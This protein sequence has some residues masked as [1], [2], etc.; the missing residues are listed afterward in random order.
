[1][2]L[3]ISF[4]KPKIKI[5][6]KRFYQKTFLF[7]FSLLLSNALLAVPITWTGG[8]ANNLWSN[9]ANWSTGT[10]PN[11][12]DDVTIPAGSGTI[13]F[14]YVNRRVQSLVI[15]TGSTVNILSGAKLRLIGSVLQPLFNY[16]TLLVNGKLILVNSINIGLVN[17]G[18]LDNRGIIW[19][20]NMTGTGLFNQGTV[21][22][23][24]NGEIRFLVVGGTDV[25]TSS[26]PFI[27]EGTIQFL[28]G[29][30]GEGMSVG[31][32]FEN[33]STG[34]I[35]YGDGHPGRLSISGTTG[36][37]DGDI[38]FVNSTRIGYPIYVSLNSS[39]HNGASGVIKIDGFTSPTGMIVLLNSLFE[40]EGHLGVYNDS[41]A[42]GMQ[43]N[44]TFVNEVGASI[45]M[46]DLQT[47][48]IFTNTA[49]LEN[50]GSIT[51]SAVATGLNTTGNI[52]NFSGASMHFEDGDNGIIN[53]SPGVFTNTDGEI[54]LG[55]IS[56]SDI[57]NF[58]LFYNLECGLIEGD[59]PI[60]NDATFE[61][62]GW[63]SY[64]TAG[65]NHTGASLI[66]NT[67]IV[68][69]PYDRFGTI[70]DNQ[71]TRVT[72]LTN[73]QVNVPYPDAFDVANIT[74]SD[75][76]DFYLNPALNDFAGTYDYGTN[77]YTPNKSAVGATALYTKAHQN[78][79]RVLEIRIDGSILPIVNNRPE[80]G[81][82]KRESA[83]SQNISTNSLRNFPNPTQGVFQTQL[84]RLTAG[85]Y[86]LQLLNAQGQ[87]IAK[88]QGDATL[89][90]TP[91][92]DLSE[93]PAGM[94]WTRLFVDEKLIAQ[95]KIMQIK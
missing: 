27:N 33:R 76:A 41:G 62:D 4:L 55:N 95:E 25:L 60:L 65:S 24:T 81:W 82:M 80:E 9:T 93:Y 30:T 74:G 71:E 17:Y 26:H 12:A 3:T 87:V 67:G 20:N 16:G 69:D 39:F 75:F 10:I 72:A 56:N 84:P 36:F 91:T 8:G 6:K 85:S 40:N 79:T 86:D 7:I 1:M 37:N 54:T 45:E 51:M 52:S 14:N 59:G 42:I 68:I 58:S 50:H 89:G 23:R 61:N 88:Q 83:A 49:D 32:G 94:Y 5:M 38:S 63:L 31:D 18:F 66:V 21:H 35:E 78:C 90:D 70:L 48:V 34:A 44:G 46:G 2:P 92:F 11:A 19:M 43:L 13:R 57:Q 15:N 53:Y 47:G 64:L 73:P 29:G 22:N 28:T 77:T